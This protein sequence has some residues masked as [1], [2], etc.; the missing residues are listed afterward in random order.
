ML[1][2]HQNVTLLSSRTQLR[3]QTRI[4]KRPMARNLFRTVLLLI[5][6]FASAAAM[7]QTFELSPG[8]S[9][10]PPQQKNK[11][12]AP[13][14]KGKPAPQAQPV[15]PSSGIGWG[16]GIEVARQAR[17]AQ[18]ALEK[19]NYNDAA[20]FAQR[21]ANSAPQDTALWFTLGYAA[22]LSGAI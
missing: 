10:P 9:N 18:Q 13:P 19:G 8:Q 4:A 2:G 11:K 14:A 1:D 3:R 12:Q 6:S 5:V 20:F 7:A 16:S 15:T 22:R 21:A 17:S